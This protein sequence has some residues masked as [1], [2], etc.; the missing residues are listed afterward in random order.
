MK[1]KIL[2]IVLIM[3]LIVTTVACSTHTTSP[4]GEIIKETKLSIGYRE[5]LTYLPAYIAKEK[6][7][8][9]QEGLDVK[10][11][12]FDSTNQMVEAILNGQLDGGVGGINAIA[13]LQI[14]SKVPGTFKI[15]NVGE[16]SKS[17][18]YQK[19]T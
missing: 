12:K 9:A 1:T 13:L 3:L 5:H 16:F 10:L 15:T 6:G 18:D 19:R 2:F 17:F 11:V 8:F 7:Y 14:E 4:T